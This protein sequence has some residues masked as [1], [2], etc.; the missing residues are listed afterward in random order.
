M[1]LQMYVHQKV[2]QYFICLSP[3][4][5]PAALSEEAAFYFLAFCA[6]LEKQTEQIEE[7]RY[8]WY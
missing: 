4:V 7:K 3:S 1:R 8:F 2:E 5:H 6:D